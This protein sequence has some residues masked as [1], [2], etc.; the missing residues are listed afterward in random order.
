MTEKTY[1]ALVYGPDGGSFYIHLEG[2]SVMDILTRN[3]P[4]KVIPALRERPIHVS[5]AMIAPDPAEPYALTLLVIASF[6]DDGLLAGLDQA[7][8]LQFTAVDISDLSGIPVTGLP[9]PGWLGDW[10]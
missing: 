2:S 7:Y 6:T 4:K 8:I 1:I 10:A 9:V 5:K 3:G